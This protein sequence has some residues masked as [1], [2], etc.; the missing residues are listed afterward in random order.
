VGVYSSLSLKEEI[1][2]KLWIIKVNWN[3]S[4]NYALFFVKESV[5]E[6]SANSILLHFI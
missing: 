5:S 1:Y 3:F 2:L 6:D 4:L